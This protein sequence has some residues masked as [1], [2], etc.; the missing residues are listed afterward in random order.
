MVLGKVANCQIACA[1]I[2][3]KQTR[4]K[5]LPAFD[6]RVE[7]VNSSRNFL[8]LHKTI[9]EA[10]DHKR[11]IF[12]IASSTAPAGVADVKLKL[13]V[14]DPT[15]LTEK[16]CDNSKTVIAEWKDL[17]D[18]ELYHTFVD[19]RKPFLRLL[20]AHCIRAVEK[21]MALGWIESPLDESRKVRALELA[22]V[23][24]GEKVDSIGIFSI[25]K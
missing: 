5:G 6:L 2:W 19:N 15:L 18:K 22:R 17:Q 21:A 3:P 7:D 11:I 1:H 20:S 12:E 23:S 9:E 10:F 4:G 25:A 16:I 13:V 24:L 8:R 14:L